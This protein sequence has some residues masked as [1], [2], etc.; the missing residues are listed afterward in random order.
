MV[1]LKFPR[2]TLPKIIYRALKVAT[3]VS[4]SFPIEYTSEKGAIVFSKYLHNQQVHMAESEVLLPSANTCIISRSIWLE[5]F[6]K[7]SFL[8]SRV[9]SDVL[10]QQIIKPNIHCA[11]ARSSKILSIVKIL[12]LC[13]LC[14]T[15]FH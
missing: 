4:S 12:V 3:L 7:E 15:L 10:A 2:Q 6:R 11:Y 8:S 14:Y 5:P 9:A 1:T 13:P